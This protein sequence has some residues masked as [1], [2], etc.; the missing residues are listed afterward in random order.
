MTVLVALVLNGKPNESFTKIPI[1][2]KVVTKLS[3]R[4]VSYLSE[5]SRVNSSGRTV[6][7]EFE[8]R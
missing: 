5:S 6:R 8:D 7:L 4:N 3:N 1:T 2:E